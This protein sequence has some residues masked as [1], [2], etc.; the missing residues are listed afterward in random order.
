[1][2][3]GTS[4]GRPGTRAGGSAFSLLC[5]LLTP[6]IVAVLTVAF[7]GYALWRL[8]Y[9]L[10]RLACL[11]WQGLRAR[12]SRRP[13]GGPRPT[14]DPRPDAD[15]SREEFC[16]VNYCSSEHG[17]ELYRRLES[18]AGPMKEQPCQR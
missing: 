9:L 2:R 3:A 17:R 7:L 15:I 8:A 11:A 14:P 5:L 13:P 1:M 18:A 12:A 6:L 10:W 4:H 16:R